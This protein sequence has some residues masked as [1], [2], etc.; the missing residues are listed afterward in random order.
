MRIKGENEFEHQESFYLNSAK[1]V[2]ENA[3]HIV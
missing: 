2:K 1:D 3:L